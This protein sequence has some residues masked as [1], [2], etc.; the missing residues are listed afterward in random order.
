[1]PETEI[2]RRDQIFEKMTAITTSFFAPLKKRTPGKFPPPWEFPPPK[3]KGANVPPKVG[4]KNR[5]GGC[6]CAGDSVAPLEDFLRNVPA[7]GATNASV[8]SQEMELRDVFSRYVTSGA[9]VRASPPGSKRSR[10]PPRSKRSRSPPGSERSR[11]P[12]RPQRT[13]SPGESQKRRKVERT[14][15][16]ELEKSC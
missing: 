5:N 14:L 16:K 10:S 12:P 6:A 4:P 11:S 13:R 15:G 2:V 8:A 1:M 7:A 3:A 9:V